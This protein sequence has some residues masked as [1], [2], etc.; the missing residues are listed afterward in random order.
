MVSNKNEIHRYLDYYNKNL[1][2]NKLLKIKHV[3]DLKNKI[4][5]SYKKYVSVTNINKEKLL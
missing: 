3:P 2:L 1:M 4:Y 5:N